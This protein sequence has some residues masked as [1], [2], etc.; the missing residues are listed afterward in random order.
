MSARSEPVALSHRFAGRRIDA[1]V[2]PVGA[3][4][5]GLGVD[6][7]E[8]VC[9][10]ASGP[11]ASSGAVLVPW[12]N[13]IRGARWV[14][15]G[16]PQQLEV[17]EGGA[18]NALHGLLAS[19]PFAVSAR[20]GSSVALAATIRHPVGYPFDLDVVVRYRLDPTGVRSSIS[21]VNRSLAAAPVAVGVHPYLRVGRSAAADLRLHVDADRTLLLGA[22]NLPVAE[23]PAD[24]APVDGTAF[25]LR[26]PT[27]LLDAP[28]HAAYTG[29]RST[30]GR[31]RL[32]LVDARTADAVTVWADARFRWAQVYVTDE[33]PG[34]P[35]SARAIAL[36]PMT[37]PPDA[38]NSG[39]DLHWLPPSSR[40]VLNWG[41]DRES[42]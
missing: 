29:L 16:E 18:G 39:V 9:G 35:I 6:G 34:L 15:D 1:L 38:F 10:S 33:L 25:D 13:R 19:T 30:D 11:V 40:W 37:A 31:V 41:I 36:E 17:T 24:G 23:A 8:L 26:V 28:A 12:P 14:L 32:R 27:S 2:S 5:Q 21:V 22:D 7:V 3:S 42:A 20:D 4:L